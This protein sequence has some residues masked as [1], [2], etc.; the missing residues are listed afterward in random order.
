MPLPKQNPSASTHP[1]EPLLGLIPGPGKNSRNV[2]KVI[3]ATFAGLPKTTA[4]V[5]ANSQIGTPADH[6]PDASAIR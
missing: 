1:P 4:E 6:I 5:V 2:D 3:I